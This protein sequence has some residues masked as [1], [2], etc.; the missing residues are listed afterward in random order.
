[1]ST[2]DRL[3]RQAHRATRRTFGQTVTFDGTDVRAI[4]DPSHELIEPGNYGSMIRSVVPMVWLDRAIIGRDPV[5]GDSVSVDGQ[6][7][8]IVDIEPDGAG[9][10]KCRLGRGYW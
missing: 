3:A 5:Q 9:G 8:A 10:F 6:D 1:M 2:W 4:Y 7:Y